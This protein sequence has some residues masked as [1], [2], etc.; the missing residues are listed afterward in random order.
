[1]INRKI[2]C[3]S[4][5]RGAGWLLLELVECQVRAAWPPDPLKSAYVIHPLT[6]NPSTGLEK[7]WGTAYRVGQ[8]KRVHKL[9]ATILSDL[10]RFSKNFSLEDSLADLK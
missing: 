7:N 5:P 2:F 9:T 4:G 6:V 1:M 10:N 3:K 8:K